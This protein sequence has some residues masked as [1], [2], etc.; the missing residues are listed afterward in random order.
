MQDSVI[1]IQIA[2]LVYFL[3]SFTDWLD[4]ILARRMNYT[5]RFGQFMDP[6]ADKI[7]VSTALGLFAYKGYIYVWMVLIIIL[8]DVIIT[9][10]RIY[11]SYFGKTIIT[12]SFGKWKTFIQ[13]GFVFALLIYLNIPLVPS[14]ELSYNL[15][16]WLLWTTI[17]ATIVTILTLASG[18][19]YLLHNRRH[20][21]EI[22]KR[23]VRK[24]TH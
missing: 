15:S 1:D 2:A 12:S 23:S 16:D 13:M 17:S 9:A 22:Y 8:R 14:I 19:H 4:G 21:Y 18:V 7:L 24:W 3:A 6:V 5:T 10:L 11:A 20:I